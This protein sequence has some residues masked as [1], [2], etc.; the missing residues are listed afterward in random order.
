MNESF[1][2]QARK[3]SFNSTDS[4]AA[5]VFQSEGSQNSIFSNF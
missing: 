4:N 5:V 3:A 2:D 1:Q